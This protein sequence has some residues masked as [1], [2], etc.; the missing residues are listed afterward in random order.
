MFRNAWTKQKFSFGISLERFSGTTCDENGVGIF[1][2]RASNSESKHLLHRLIQCENLSLYLDPEESNLLSASSQ[3]SL[4]DALHASQFDPHKPFKQQY[5]ILSPCSPSVVVTKNE[6]PSQLLPR[7]MLKV[8]LV[9]VHLNLLKKQYVC[10][11]LLTY[12][13]ESQ[14]ISL[15]PNKK[16]LVAV[17]SNPRAWC[18]A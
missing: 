2:D 3:S 14:I 7:W 4:T 15:N 8:E 16:P 18:A 10:L 11:N 12:A 6:M 17:A 9:G 1:V 5:Y 13:M